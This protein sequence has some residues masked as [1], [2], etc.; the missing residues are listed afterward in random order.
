[1]SGADS[2]AYSGLNTASLY[3]PLLWQGSNPVVVNFDRWT[4]V[5]TETQRRET[6]PRKKV[7]YDWRLYEFSPEELGITYDQDPSF[8]YESASEESKNDADMGFP[9]KTESRRRS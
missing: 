2:V 1:M 3:G 9:I 6:M 4:D 8:E 7:D 5:R